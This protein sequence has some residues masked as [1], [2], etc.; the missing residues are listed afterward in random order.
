[1]ITQKIVGCTFVRWVD[2]DAAR[3]SRY[4]EVPGA[5][6]ASSLTHQNIFGGENLLGEKFLT[7]GLALLTKTNIYRARLHFDQQSKLFLSLRFCY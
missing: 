3:E 7:Y 1:M 6:T 5:L 2:Q 4:S